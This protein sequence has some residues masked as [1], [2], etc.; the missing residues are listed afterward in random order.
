MPVEVRTVQQAYRFPLDP[1]PAQARAF[2]SHAG[3]ARY[4]FNWGLAT[5]AAALDARQAQK[6]AG[7]ELSVPVPNHFALCLLWTEFKDHGVVCRRCGM[8]VTAGGD[9]DH[10]ASSRGEGETSDS[11]RDGEPHDPGVGLPWVSANFSGTYQAALRDAHQAWQNFFDSRS[12]KRKGRFA[13]RPKFK[14]KRNPKRSFQ[15]HGTGLRIADHRHVV[16]P[17]IGSVRTHEPTKKLLRRLRKG[18]TACATCRTSGVVK[19]ETKAGTKERKCGTCRG[20][21]QAPYARIVRA[22]VSLHTNN[23]WYISI[24]VEAQREIRTGPSQRQREGGRIGLDLGVR[25]LLVTSRGDRIANPRHL[26]KALRRL[27]HAQQDLSRTEIGSGRRERSRKRVAQMHARV[28][29]LRADTCHKITTDLVHRYA[30]IAVEGWDIQQTAERG[31]RHL[32]TRKRRERN[33]NLADAALG[34]LR[35]QLQ[36]KGRWYGCEVDVTDPHAPTGRTCSACGAVR[37]KPLPP[38]EELFMCPSCGYAVDRRVNTA[39]SVARLARESKNGAAG[40]GSEAKNARGGGVRPGASRRAGQSPSN[41]EA[42][43]GP[44]GPGKTGTP[45]G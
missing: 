4:A 24:T 32:E 11:C 28:G 5:K 38:A 27:R 20:T 13:G 25:S 35:W 21:G 31:S 26:D 33:R 37:T 8:P 45:A 10:A 14:S 19:V 15:T 36:S 16:L 43:A 1:T 40:S 3:G 42:R 39:R 17:K 6:D 7:E 30:G 22:T 29:H 9:G 18:E 2:M 44:K 12:G 23:R 41:R 34:N